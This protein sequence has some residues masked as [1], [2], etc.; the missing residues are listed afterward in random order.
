MVGVLPAPA[1]RLLMLRA[2]RPGRAMPGHVLAQV[3]LRSRPGSCRRRNPRRG[4][5]R[6]RAPGRNDELAQT[7]AR[8]GRTVVAAELAV[9]PVAWA[10]GAAW[11]S[12]DQVRPDGTSGDRSCQQYAGPALP[13]QGRRRAGRD[14]GDASCTMPTP[15]AKQTIQRRAS[16]NPRRSA[17]AS[18]WPRRCCGQPHGEAA[19]LRCG[20]R[21]AA[22]IG[23][24][25]AARA[26][27]DTSQLWRPHRRSIVDDL[28]CRSAGRAGRSCGEAQPPRARRTTHV[29]VTGTDSRGCGSRRPRRSLR[30][31]EAAPTA[32]LPG[33]LAMTQCGAPPAG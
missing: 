12:T 24:R 33:R 7:L 18:A 10:P 30:R 1:G 28:R 16:F 2:K 23:P 20:H 13:E 9:G 5:R 31:L 15:W 22:R 3:A 11:P 14:S 26:T 17:R 19:A 21:R 6:A 4:C 29:S 27:P 25:R 32:A 8:L